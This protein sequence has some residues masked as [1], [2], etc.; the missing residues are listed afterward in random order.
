MKAPFL[1]GRMLFDSMTNLGIL[2]P[3]RA[4]LS[5]LG[6][7]LG[8]LR[9]IEPDAA[10]GNGGLGRLAA[11]FMDGPPAARGRGPGARRSR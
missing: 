7:D 1:I 10:L 9:R 6:V 5:Q 8:V 2:E 3:M 11:C 4:A